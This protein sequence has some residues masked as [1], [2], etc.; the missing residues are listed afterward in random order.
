MEKIGFY[1]NKS[2]NLKKGEKFFDESFSHDNEETIFGKNPKWTKEEIGQFK[3]NHGYGENEK[4]KWTRIFSNEVIPFA[5]NKDGE[6]DLIQGRLGDCQTISF[7]H[8]LKRNMNDDVFSS[9]FS[10]CKPIEGY[11]EVFFYFEEEDKTISKKR[12]FVD[13]FIP[14]KAISSGFKFFCSKKVYEPLFSRY[15]EFNNF[16]VGKYLLIEKAYAKIKG[17]YM[18]IVGKDISFHLIGVKPE[19]KYL[20]EILKEKILRRD[21]DNKI[22]QELDSELDKIE[23]YKKLKI[24]LDDVIKSKKNKEEKEKKIKELKLNLGILEN[25]YTKYTIYKNNYLYYSDK[26]EIFNEI[27]NDADLN[28]IRVSSENKM[29][30]EP[31]SHFGIYGNHMY[32]YVNGI[33]ENENLFFHLWNPHG[34]NPNYNNNNYNTEFKDINKINLDGLKNGNI[35]L[36]FDRF[37]LSFRRI[38]YQSKEDIRKI[39]NKF[40]PINTFILFRLLGYDWDFLITFIWIRIYLSKGKDNKTLFNDLVNEI[41]EKKEISKEKIIWFLYIWNELKDEIIKES[42]SI[43]RKKLNDIK[44]GDLEKIKNL[45]YEENE[46]SNTYLSRISK[47]QIELIKEKLEEIRKEL[48]PFIKKI[49]EEFI[50]KRRKKQKEEEEERSEREREE[51]ERRTWQREEEERRRR[52]REEEKR[53]RES[54]QYEIRTKLCN[55]NLDGVFLRR[56]DHI[57]IWD[58]HHGNNQKFRKIENDDGSVSFVNG[59]NAIDVR[60]A[61]VRNGN[62]I[63][64]FDRNKTGAQKFFLIDRG[65]GWVSIHSALNQRYCLDVN[66]F[67][68]DNGTKVILWEYKNNNNNNQLFKLV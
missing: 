27:K 55:K 23:K 53:R 52:Q 14:Y 66:N 47:S 48:E 51:E 26:Y 62:A 6:L 17:S 33:K 41:G 30:I 19:T 8:C 15:K 56:N 38:S 12:V 63:Q 31:K 1:E 64:I 42:E 24:E 37:I 60:G 20:T 11:F 67:G 28:L 32:D 16:M 44:D 54:Y 57:H 7:I 2:P 18:D 3:K 49:T 61:I 46:K 9:I 65:D 50:E 59:N 13:D 45:L 5:E 68:T 4:I 36:S 39:Y 43:M 22:K 34:E 29:C 25:Y 10:T 58:V 21:K 35:I 40:N